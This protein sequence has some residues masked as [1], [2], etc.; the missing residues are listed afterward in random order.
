MKFV[1]GKQQ[2]YN[3]NLEQEML[4]QYNLKHFIEEDTAN[5]S[6]VIDPCVTNTQ[7]QSTVIWNFWDRTPTTVFP[8]FV[9]FDTNRSYLQGK[10]S[11]SHGR[12]DE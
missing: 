2:K 7:A 12:G 4:Q 5:F 3:D 10:K 11:T 9:T 6:S 1:T 8:D